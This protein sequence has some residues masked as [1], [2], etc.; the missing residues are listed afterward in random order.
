MWNAFSQEEAHIS[1][2]SGKKEDEENNTSNAYYAHCKNKGSYKKFK[3]TKK[4]V[5]LSKIECCNC[6]YMGHY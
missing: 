1:L 5:D 4:V 6:H 2:V 3:E